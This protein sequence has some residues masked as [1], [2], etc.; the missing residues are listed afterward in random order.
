MCVWLLG[1]R[2]DSLGL[3]IETVEI[4]VYDYVTGINLYHGLCF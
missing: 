4:C 1:V 3:T 2:H